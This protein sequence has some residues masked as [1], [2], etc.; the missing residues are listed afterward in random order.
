MS[1][2]LR[3]NMCNLQRPG[4]RVRDVPKSDIDK[5][6]PLPVQYT[7]RYWIHHL[8]RSNV[9]PREHPGILDFFQTR[10]LFW[11]ETLALISR[12]S[13]GVIMIRLLEGMLAERDAYIDISKR[14]DASRR[15]LFSRITAKWRQKPASDAS[16]PL[17]LILY[18]A[19]R[20]LLSHSSIIEEAPLQ[21][22]CSAILFSP[23]TS[24]T[25][26]LY[27]HQVPKWILHRPTISESW[28]PYLQILNHSSCVNA[29]A[30]SPDG[31]LVASGSRE[32]TIRL[33]DALTGTDK[34]P[35]GFCVGGSILAQ[36]PAG[37]V[38]IWRQANPALGRINRYR[39]ARLGRPFRL[40]DGSGILA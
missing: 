12:L 32:K 9:D 1:C 22:Y 4:M 10:F 28:S 34:R 21:V 38:R 3:R 2:H 14:S 5:S 6:I 17:H 27:S 25:R 18:D 7:C 29:V 19:N 37:S 30:F 39:A 40:G 11:L 16:P 23:K 26:R 15:P 20:F 31:R 36:W 24:I 35:F 33:W 13:D 8:Q